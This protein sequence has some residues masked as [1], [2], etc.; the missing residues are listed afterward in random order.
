MKMTKKQ[1]L[2]ARI[3]WY[4]YKRR[5]RQNETT[6]QFLSQSILLINY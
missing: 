5:R 2:M 3:P 1:I 4:K 6:K